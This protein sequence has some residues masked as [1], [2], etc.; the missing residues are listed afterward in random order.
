MPEPNELLLSGLYAITPDGIKREDLLVRVEAA[1]RGGTRLIQYRDKKRNPLQQAKIARELCVL[2]HRYGARFVVN[3]NL[4]LALD[5][6]ADGL[7][8]GGEDGDLAAARKALG[9]D[10][11]L[12]ASCYASFDLACAAKSAG[13]DYVAFGAVYPSPT[14]PHAV[15]APLSL[16]GRCRD[17][18]CIPAC[19]IGGITLGN[20][21][22][23]LSAGASLLAIITD[24][25]ESP[26]IES[27]SMA[28]QQLFKGGQI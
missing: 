28:F 9:K 21:P 13:A 1:L 16:F 10:K 23:L 3:D 5:V 2:C 4:A 25:F 11:L 18:L 19:A 27:H 8:L 24:L 22:T 12:G 7:H 15:H 26:D 14:K 20:A 6:D 17:E